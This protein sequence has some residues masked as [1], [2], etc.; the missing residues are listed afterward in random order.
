MKPESKLM[1]DL[2]DTYAVGRE[3][4][5]VGC[6]PHRR[7]PKWFTEI[8]ARAF[9]V[10]ALEIWPLN[11]EAIDAKGIFRRVYC[12]NIVDGPPKPYDLIFWWQGPE[13]LE[14]NLAYRTLSALGPR[15]IAG[16]PYGVY[17][18]G[19]EYGN[20]Y[21]VHLTHFLPEHFTPLGY[22]AVSFG[23]VNCKRSHIILWK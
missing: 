17:E 21:E 14:V 19:P 10:D 8:A 3:V 4:L 13:H 16:C 2:L 22:E 20:P 6:H 15:V 18:Q 9:A 11:A 23:P 7:S 12:G 1:M 5:Y